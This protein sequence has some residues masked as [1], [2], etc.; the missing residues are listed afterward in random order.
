M[1]VQ[2]SYAYSDIDCCQDWHRLFIILKNQLKYIYNNLSHNW[3]F[4]KLNVVILMITCI[5]T[6][7]I[8]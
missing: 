7:R 1:L 4:P 2:K 3:V 5:S 6:G 8:T